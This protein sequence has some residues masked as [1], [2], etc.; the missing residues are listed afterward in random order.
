M[1]EEDK[2]RAQNTY[3][4]EMLARL[5]SIERKGENVIGYLCHTIGDRIYFWKIELYN[6]MLTIGN[7]SI[8]LENLIETNSFKFTLIY[9]DG[10]EC[11]REIVLDQDG[12]LSC[13]HGFFLW[14]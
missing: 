12:N 3:T 13:S 10:K 8:S 11:E 9:P 5:C 1:S 4:E 7:D 14:K 6:E 2:E